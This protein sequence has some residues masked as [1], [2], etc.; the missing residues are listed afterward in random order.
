[1]FAG[2]GGADILTLNWGTS[3]LTSIAELPTF[4]PVWDA[5]E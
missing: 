1:M 3:E 5:G 2:L 4:S